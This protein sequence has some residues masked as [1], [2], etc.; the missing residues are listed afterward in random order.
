[1]RWTGHEDDTK[2]ADP[3]PSGALFLAESVRK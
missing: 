1:M 2:R 3:A